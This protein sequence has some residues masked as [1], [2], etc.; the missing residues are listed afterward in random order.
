MQTPKVERQV[1]WTRDSKSGHV[2][3]EERARDAGITRPRPSL[4]DRA[5]REIHPHRL[6]TVPRE[7][8]HIRPGPAAEVERAPRGMRP[9]EALEL[10]RSH[11]GVPP[12][13]AG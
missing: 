2:P 11:S 7:V 12:T 10:G 4:R 13:P 6:P 1:E 5:P 8:H 9:D 3:D